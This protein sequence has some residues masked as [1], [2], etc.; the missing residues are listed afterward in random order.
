MGGRS[1]IL[2]DTHCLIWLD[3]ADASMGRSA[4]S[5]A[6]TAIEGGELVVSV[7]SFW[8]VAL[9]AAKGRMRVHGSVV[10]WRHGLLESGI[11]ELP[12]GGGIC[13][14]AARLQDFHA[15]P[16]DR[17]IGATAQALGATLVTADHR[18]LAWTGPLERHDARS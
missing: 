2:L 15:D 12:L 9:L 1:L 5:L 16:A 13:I 4:R 7:I 10:R 18:I 14:A 11:V 17:L 8:E 6:D 3:Q